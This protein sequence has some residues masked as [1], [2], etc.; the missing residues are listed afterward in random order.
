MLQFNSE[1]SISI[2]SIYQYRSI[3]FKPIL[4]LKVNLQSHQ[5]EEEQQRGVGADEPGTAGATADEEREHRRGRGWLR[6]RQASLV[7]DSGVADGAGE[8]EPRGHADLPEAQDPA[9]V[10]AIA[11]L[12]AH[13]RAPPPG[14]SCGE[15]LFSISLENLSLKHC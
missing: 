2:K 6:G 9:P 14:L 1:N 3:D 7:G 8:P 13:L 10:P 11:T 4:S 15:Y 12:A 5:I